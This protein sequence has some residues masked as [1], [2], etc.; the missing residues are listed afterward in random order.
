MIFGCHWLNT[1]TTCLRSGDMRLVLLVLLAFSTTVLARRCDSYGKEVAAAL[2]AYFVDE[3]E[4]QKS[5]VY[6]D[7]SSFPQNTQAPYP[8]H[9]LPGFVPSESFRPPSFRQASGP[10]NPAQEPTHSPPLSQPAWH[11][12][13]DSQSSLHDFFHLMSQKA[14]LVEKYIEVESEL[15]R[16]KSTS[17]AELAKTVL[18]H[19][20]A[21]KDLETELNRYLIEA[22]TFLNWVGRGVN[23][24]TGAR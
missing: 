6:G 9:L 3:S 12:P 21:S 24:P 4:V 14:R 2:R 8:T 5:D 17:Q 19:G 10:I 7:D 11:A 22:E 18:E 15:A 23:N 13:M 16:K 20:A 1:T